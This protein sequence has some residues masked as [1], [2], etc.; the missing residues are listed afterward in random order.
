MSCTLISD[1][2]IRVTPTVNIKDFEA[3]IEKMCR[4]AGD[5]VKH[6]FLQ[7]PKSHSEYLLRHYC[8]PNVNKGYS[9]EPKDICSVR[10]TFRAW[11]WTT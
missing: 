7:V 4:E 11:G 8:P 9:F 1:F 10:P 2:D 3:Q 5:G 6:E